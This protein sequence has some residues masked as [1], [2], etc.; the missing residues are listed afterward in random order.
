MH[1]A[2]VPGQQKGDS[3]DPDAGDQSTP[4]MSSRVKWRSTTPF[5]VVSEV[6]SMV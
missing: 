6:N 1:A 4:V 5:N 2:G 3:T